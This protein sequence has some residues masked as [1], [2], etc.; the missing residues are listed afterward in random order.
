M[1]GSLIIKKSFKGSSQEYH[2]D[3]EDY[4][5]IKGFLYLED[6]DENNGAMSLFSRKK[7]KK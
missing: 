1:F 6:I 5:Q 4:T 7:V 2:L 3:H